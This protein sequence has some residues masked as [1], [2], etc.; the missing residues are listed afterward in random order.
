MRC[1]RCG[2]EKPLA[3]FGVDRGRACGLRSR[4]KEC[5]AIYNKGYRDA[6][7]SEAKERAAK[8]YRR[9]ADSV[10]VASASWRQANIVRVRELA[11]ISRAKNR[12]RNRA[13]INR[14]RREHPEHR[15]TSNSRR[16]AL[17]RKAPGAGVPRREWAN[18][19]A[20]SL[21]LCAYCNERRPLTMD[22]IEPLA[23]GGAHEVENVAAACRTCNGS[24]TDKP[25]L[26]WLAQRAAA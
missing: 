14:W 23:L 3:A 1:A 16:R 17:V 24:K 13:L 21:G 10:K 7:R 8:R 22:H 4:C 19:L 15:A 6:H 2:E 18:V 9:H 25:L 12:D 20:D 26:L 5:L 11:A